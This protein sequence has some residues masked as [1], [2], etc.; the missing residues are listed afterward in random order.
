L[1][2]LEAFAV[3][4]PFDPLF[5]S[6]PRG[7]ARDPLRSPP[8]S[9]L[10]RRPPPPL[11]GERPCAV[12]RS[13]RFGRTGALTYSREEPELD[14]VDGAEY[15]PPDEPDEDE[16][17]ELV[18]PPEELGELLPELDEPRSTALPVVSPPPRSRWAQAGA[19]PRTHAVT[20]TAIKNLPR[21][22]ARS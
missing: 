21:V 9:A 5:E 15:P 22:I 12:S 3:R 18:L 13:S 2:P 14:G 16:L 19:V 11:L 20:P 7:T 1:S 17:P 10:G 8:P 6:E 4:E